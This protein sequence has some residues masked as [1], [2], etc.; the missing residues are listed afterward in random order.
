MFPTIGPFQNLDQASCLNFLSQHYNQVL[1]SGP[2]SDQPVVTEY[3]LF[4]N[5]QED[6]PTEERVLTQLP[7][8]HTPDHPRQWQ[9]LMVTISAA[10]NCQD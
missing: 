6:H 5:V 8:Q 9:L 4:V 10:H 7:A 1:D 3:V 2:L